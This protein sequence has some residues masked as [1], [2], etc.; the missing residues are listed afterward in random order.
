MFSDLVMWGFFKYTKWL[1]NRD[2]VNRR[3]Y[4]R[5]GPVYSL[6]RSVCKHASSRHFIG[7]LPNR[8]TKWVLIAEIVSMATLTLYVCFSISLLI[9]LVDYLN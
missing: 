4:Y 1:T 2:L 8:F 9:S 5:T 3:R 7:S 6:Y